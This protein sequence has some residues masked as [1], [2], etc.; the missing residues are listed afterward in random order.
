M[1]IGA[2]S[3][4]PIPVEELVSAVVVTEVSL[5]GNGPLPNDDSGTCPA[6]AAVQA[7][8]ARGFGAGC[9]AEATTDSSVVG[10][11]G[12]ALAA[13]VGE[14]A[15]FAFAGSGSAPRSASQLLLLIF[16]L[17]LERFHRFGERLDLLP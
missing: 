16:H 14:A 9:G 11:F 15:A 1:V 7:G 3:E 5:V 13:G 10:N 17:L 6:A 2:V 8:W 12:A 4:A